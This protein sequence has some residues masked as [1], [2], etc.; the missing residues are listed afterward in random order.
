MWLRAD[1]HL[2]T[3]ADREFKYSGD[4]NYYRS[5]YV[6]A[7][8]N[9]GI[10]V[11]VIANHNKFDY[12]EFKALRSKA[13]EQ[14]VFL[15][16]GVELSVD[17]G[18][19]GIH[20]LVVFSDE[21]V[22]EGQD[23]IKQ[24]LNVAFEGKTPE[25][26]ENENGRSSLSLLDTIKKLEV[27]QKDFF[28][29]FAHV[30]QKSW[31]WS[32]LEGGR[33][34]EL[35]QNEFFRRRTLGFQK[36]RTHND[37]NKKCRTKVT[38][39]LDSWY[40]AEVEG[41][42]PKKIEEIGRGEECFLKLSAFTFEAVKFALID[43]KNRSRLRDV[44]EI[45]HSHIDKISFEGGTLD[46]RS[47]SFS[48]EL[49]TLIGIRGSGKSSVLETLRYGLGIPLEENTGD[50][51]YKQK[52][53]ELTLGSGGRVV[54]DAIDRY[55]RY[56]QIRRI[57]KESANVFIDGKLQPGISIRETVLRKPLF[58]GQKE[59][60]AGKNSGKDLIEK[61]L[62]A[63]CDEIRR[64]IAE[65]KTRVTEAI[66]RLSK[67]HNVDEFIEE[68][69]RVKRDT[70]FRLNFYKEHD[71]EGKLQK[72]LGFEA[73]IRR[74]E[75]GIALIETF[76]ADVRD[77]LAEHE[78]ELRNF[79][80]YT[81]AD[82]TD[83]FRRF[84][85]QFAL[86]IQSADILK[87]ELAKDETVLNA[88]KEEHSKLIAARDGLADEFAAIERTLAEELKTAAEKNISSD[89]FLMLKRKLAAA[90]TALNELSKS[91]GQKTEL[92][93]SLREDLRRLNDLWNQEFQIINRELDAVSQRNTA[94]KFSIGFRED[95]DAF[96]G[97]FRS[98]FRG[99]GVREATFQNIVEKYQD[100]V[101]I[102][103]DFDNAKNLFGSNPDNFA[104]LF[105]QNLNALLTYQTPNK[106]TILYRG[107]ELAH[108]SLGQRASALILFVLGLRENDVII[109]DQPEDD[110]DNQTI[111]ED[112][113]K[114]IR[115]LKP[116]MQF[117]FATHNP[118]IPVLG[119]AEQIHACSFTD[120]KVSV[121]SGGIDDP[122]QQGKIV[123]IMEGGREAFERRKEIYQ[124]W[125]P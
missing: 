67:V 17:D 42:D 72:R 86:I 46:G 80:G 114:L 4:E 106:F 7:L 41:S 103:F 98:I 30:E 58:F 3:K 25:Q 93:N 50:R 101:S 111:Y 96:L 113:I 2:H 73:D 97:Y 19:N 123:K 124:T 87:A 125:K 37:P 6:E 11:G 66:D 81:S 5:A 99:S 45:K 110:L 65:Q 14:D 107:T 48:P 122:A 90:E 9:A 92:Q 52:L 91:S 77:L 39:W 59:L 64:E 109:I 115:E 119:D 15:L 68:K 51:E 54:I 75:K 117:I 69:I 29:V 33:L 85:T 34:S 78:D 95:R 105:L 84:E 79:P 8:K 116:E 88:L 21:W 112:V 62:G 53:V 22:A 76:A 35:G 120:E 83:F 56:C 70:E 61:L 49:N 108:H 47:I 102:Y 94:L 23:F 74:S 13:R 71:L 43:Y 27:Y 118:N 60:A 36:V 16:L 20:T 82:N 12:G 57:W 121:Q 44:P 32:G 55:G 26:Y 1:F 104:N 40:P 63:K 24:F 31:L 100:F 10:S 28:I 18:A 38:Q 89:E